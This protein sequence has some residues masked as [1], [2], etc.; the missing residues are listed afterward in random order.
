MRKRRLA[1]A[2]ERPD[3]LAHGEA[4]DLGHADVE[5]NA[6]W[7]LSFKRR[8]PFGATVGENDAVAFIFERVARERAVRFVVVDNQD[9]ALRLGFFSH[10]LPGEKSLDRVF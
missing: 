4:I 6:V 5:E 9:G 3:Q 1:T 10:R 7:R 8:D 2:R